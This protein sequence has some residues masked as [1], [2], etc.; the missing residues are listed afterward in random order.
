[1]FFKIGVLKIFAN[2]TGKH[3]CWSLFLVKL[4]AWQFKRIENFFVSIFFPSKPKFSLMVLLGF[5]LIVCQ[6]QWV[7]YGSVEN[8]TPLDTW[9]LVN[10]H[11]NVK[12]LFVSEKGP[13][14][15]YPEM[16]KMPFRH[17][18]TTSWIKKI[19]HYLASVIL[20]CLLWKQF[21]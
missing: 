11:G 7:T 21:R 2:F 19:F 5:C 6:F 3:L 15:S 8:N 17:N 16:S 12:F 14:F 20:S 9:H 13:P 18:F 10:T 4:Q 1:M